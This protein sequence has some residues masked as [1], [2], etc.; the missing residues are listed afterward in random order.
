MLLWCVFSCHRNTTTVLLFTLL[1]NYVW[2][3]QT[4]QP[5]ISEYVT[6]TI[7]MFSRSFLVHFSLH[8][9]ACVEK[10]TASLGVSV[11]LNL[12]NTL[13]PTA[14][15]HAKINLLQGHDFLTHNMSGDP[16]S[17]S[18]LLVIN[19]QTCW[20]NH[21][22]IGCACYTDESSLLGWV[23]CAPWWNC[24][25]TGPSSVHTDL[26]WWSLQQWSR[27]NWNCLLAI[28]S[29]ACGS[30]VQIFTVWLILLSTDMRRLAWLKWFRVSEEVAEMDELRRNIIKST[31]SLALS[32]LSSDD[33]ILWI[34]WY[35]TCSWNALPSLSWSVA[36]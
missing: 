20:T 25:N 6:T 29:T 10:W 18:L 35:R 8:T 2:L 27:V 14:Y 1:W 33:D 13:T 31:L 9:L 26:L 22:S 32:S 5:C 28:K 23:S 21:S 34:S 11:K 12:N 36:H 3:M 16:N 30:V 17:L 7:A 24:A 19:L 4:N 15:L